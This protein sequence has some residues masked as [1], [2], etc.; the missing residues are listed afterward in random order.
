M[1]LWTRALDQPKPHTQSQTGVADSSRAPGLTSVLQYPILWLPYNYCQY[2]SLKDFSCKSKTHM[3]NKNIYTKDTSNP[4]IYLKV[5]F[6]CRLRSIATHWDHF[7]RR[8][9]ICLSV[10]HTRIAM[11]RRRHMHSSECCLYFLFMNL[12]SYICFTPD[13]LMKIIMTLCCFFEINMP[14]IILLLCPFEDK[15]EDV[16]FL[17]RN[18]K[19]YKIRKKNSSCFEETTQDTKSNMPSHMC[20]GNCFL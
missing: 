8:L 18:F 6:L 13:F 2:C 11:F 1:A 20:E 4:E 14:F 12:R 9:S 5:Q 3:K 16:N 7:V 10:Y 15:R 19:I 17:S